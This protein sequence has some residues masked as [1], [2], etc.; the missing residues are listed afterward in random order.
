VREKNYCLSILYLKA[1]E[2][3]QDQPFSNIFGTTSQALIE[4]FASLEEIA[5]MPLERLVTW[6]DAKGR[7]RFPD[8][9]RLA[10]ELQQVAQESYPLDLQLQQPVNYVLT[11]SFQLLNFLERQIQR[12]NTA[13]ALLPLRGCQHRPDA[14]CR[15]CSLLSAQTR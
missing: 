14:R 1:S 6:L 4:E 13:L 7:G 12:S 5:A 15:V 8:P 2:Y 3:R 11:W 10:H 9:A